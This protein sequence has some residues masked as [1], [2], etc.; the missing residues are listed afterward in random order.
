MSLVRA[1][2]LNNAIGFNQHVAAIL[3]DFQTE[4]AWLDKEKSSVAVFLV[5]ALAGISEVGQTHLMFALREAFLQKA[6]RDSSILANVRFLGVELARKSGSAV[7]AQLRNNTDSP[8]TLNA[9]SQ[10]TVN[11][12]DF[13]NP[14]GAV[15]LP[16][17]L[18]QIQ[19]NQGTVGYKTFNLADLDLSFPFVKLGISGNVVAS[20]GIQIKVTE[21]NNVVHQWYK[22]TDS[23]YEMSSSDR[24]YI[25][26][27]TED[28]DVS[29]LFG[30]GEFG[31]RLP[32]IGSMTVRYILTEGIAGNIGSPGAIVSLTS[33]NAIN[34]VTLEG[35]VGGAN[36]KDPNF[37]KLYGSS[38]FESRGNLIRPSHW[39]ALAEFPDVADIVV[40]GQRD[41]AP[42]DPSWMN[43]VRLCVLPINSSNWGG[44]NPNPISAQWSRFI[45]HVK[46][47]CGRHLTIVPHN[48]EKILVDVLIEVYVYSDQNTALMETE[49]T[50]EI[51]KFFSRRAGVLG[52]PLIPSSDL[53]R[54]VR[55]L[56][57]GKTREGIDYVKIINPTMDVTPAARVEYVSPRSIKVLVRHTNRKREIF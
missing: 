20:D 52:R 50:Q 27:T 19:L 55:T 16:R 12:K 54:V 56:P 21:S 34:G 28:G 45:D 2:A 44:A 35:A 7:L 46:S 5:D 15:I 36:E 31:M 29:F 17:S 24:S 49:I 10:F 1:T 38:L 3:Q 11:G 4:Y 41:L 33:N 30:N 23:L 40:E 47:K 26:S 9:Y 42:D 8:L 32:E 25:E 51:R 22:H 6:R 18:L 14:N 53:D 57:D 39:E 43:T 48:P 13:Y 37:Y